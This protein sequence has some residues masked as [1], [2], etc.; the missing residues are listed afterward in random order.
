MLMC[1]P[2]SMFQL[3]TW[4][5]QAGR[6]LYRSRYLIGWTAFFSAAG[7]CFLTANLALTAVVQDNLLWPLYCMYPLICIWLIYTCLELNNCFCCC[8]KHDPNPPRPQFSWMSEHWA[9]VYLHEHLATLRPPSGENSPGEVYY[10]SDRWQTA[11]CPACWESFDVPKAHENVSSMAC[12]VYFIL[13]YFILF[14]SVYL[15]F[16][17]NRTWTSLHAFLCF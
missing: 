13:F 3:H 1:I 11:V 17:F 12:I 16:F 14:F 2:C 6:L 9:N 8:C 7:G 10:K 5:A 15:F 4:H